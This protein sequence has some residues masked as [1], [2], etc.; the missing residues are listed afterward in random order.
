MKTYHSLSKV[1]FLT[2]YS[3]KFLFIAF[4][5]IHVPLLGI[6]F[7]TLFVSEVSTL[8]IILIILGL[9]LG[10]TALTLLALNKLI[11]PII[12]GKI[13]LSQYV[14][15]RTIPQLPV[16]YKDEVGEVLKNI[17]YTIENLDAMIKEKED[18]TELISHDLKTPVHQSL[19]VLHLLRDEG[20]NP[21][22]REE[23]IDLL[24]TISNN[25]KLFLEGMIQ[26]LKSKNIEIDPANFE[27]LQIANLID[28]TINE[29]KEKTT[30][31]N[32]TVV[33]NVSNEIF[34]IGHQASLEVVLSNL[35]NNA[36][37][38]SKKNSKIIFEG[39]RTKHKVT[40]K[41]IDFGIGFN[42]EIKN[43]MFKKFIPGHVGTSGEPSTGLGLNISE[44]IIKRHG[45]ELI[46]H[47]DGENKGSVFTIILPIKQF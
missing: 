45:G 24:E 19:S 28:D 31:A 32:I 23:Y 16:F 25:Q 33:N 17:Q 4:L 12:R 41:I 27:N 13:A 1:G 26:M 35:L 47:S 34:L 29:F 9:T 40:L 15:N 21:E 7:Y 42:E 11:T 2:K 8:T 39:K 36:I 14:S 46:P 43:N 44:N 22:K 37:K 5:G 10:A 38:F 6:L 18:I 20:D 3:Y 30:S